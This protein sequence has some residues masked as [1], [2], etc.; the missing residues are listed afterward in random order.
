MRERDFMK[1]ISPGRESLILGMMGHLTLAF[2]ILSVAFFIELKNKLTTRHPR[3]ITAP[4]PNVIADLKRIPPSGIHDSKKEIDE[5]R[6][7]SRGVSKQKSKKR[8]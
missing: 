7:K 6:Y 8:T 2:I 4:K 3:V 5:N 1:L